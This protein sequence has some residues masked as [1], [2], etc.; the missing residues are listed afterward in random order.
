MADEKTFKFI[1]KRGQSKPEEKT[2]QQGEGFVMKESE[3]PP[4]SQESAGH[5][6]L[7]F[8]T[9]VMSFAT[10]A[11]IHM[12][13]SPDPVSKKRV[14]NLALAGQNIEILGIL[15]DKSKGNLSEEEKMLLENLL[16]EVRLRFVEASRA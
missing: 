1:D 11:L 14:K 13:L 15:K 9:L 5:E 2:P 4:E 12:G 16:T 3:A 7:D 10:S 8:S 6:R